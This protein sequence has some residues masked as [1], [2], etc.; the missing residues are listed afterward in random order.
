MSI[1]IDNDLEPIRSLRSLN[2]SKTPKEPKLKINFQNSSRAKSLTKPSARPWIKSRDRSEVSHVSRASKKSAQEP[3]KSGHHSKKSTG[4]RMYLNKYSRNPSK[5]GS[6]DFVTTF[7]RQAVPLAKAAKQIASSTHNDS[8]ESGSLYLD[9]SAHISL[10]KHLKSHRYTLMKPR[11][12]V[13]WD[14]NGRRKD[15]SFVNSRLESNEP[16]KTRAAH[17]SQQR[18]HRLK[19]IGSHLVSKS[20]LGGGPAAGRRPLGRK[21]SSGLNRSVAVP[22]NNKRKAAKAGAA[23]RSKRRAQPAKPLANN[24]VH[25]HSNGEQSCRICQNWLKKAEYFSE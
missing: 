4:Q 7:Q 24:Q 22:A 6:R 5:K 2:K 23:N 12:R 17:V 19:N 3:K 20:T 18:A 8:S 15:A 10:G 25:D 14:L 9:K 1:S 16:Q 13:E 11:W 21:S